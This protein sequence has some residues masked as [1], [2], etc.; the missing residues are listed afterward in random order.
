M[1]TPRIQR[2]LMLLPLYLCLPSSLRTGQGGRWVLRLLQ[3]GGSVQDELS[4]KPEE[5]KVH[6]TAKGVDNSR[7]LPSFSKIKTTIKLID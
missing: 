5:L 7:V 6:E 2:S 1:S 3:G 4:Q